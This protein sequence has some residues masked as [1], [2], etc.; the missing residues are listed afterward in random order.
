MLLLLPNLAI[1]KWRFLERN[2]MKA[3]AQPALLEEF[4]TKAQWQNICF[5]SYQAG[6][7][8]SETLKVSIRRA[9]ISKLSTAA[10]CK[11]LPSLQSA[12]GHL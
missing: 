4:S 2:L 10:R 12:F 5:H 7:F 6:K 3:K 9:G 8:L 11:H 1:Q